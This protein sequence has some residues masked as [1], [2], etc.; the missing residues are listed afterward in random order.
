MVKQRVDLF[1]DQQSFF[2]RL[3]GHIDLRL[4]AVVDKVL[5]YIQAIQQQQVQKSP[6]KPLHTAIK[7]PAAGG[8]LFAPFLHRFGIRPQIRR[9]SQD[10]FFPS[11]THP[12]G[13]A[14]DVVLIPGTTDKIPSS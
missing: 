3:D 14:F 9:P 6:T 13:V 11:L 12:L 1:N 4:E 10:W 8:Q 5:G 7:Q 2:I